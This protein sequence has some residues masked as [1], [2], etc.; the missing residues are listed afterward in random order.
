VKDYLG[1]GV[2][3]EHDGYGVTLTTENGISVTNRIYVDP[4]VLAALQRFVRRAEDAQSP[5]I[6]EQK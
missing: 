6:G 2:Y 5:P 1:D 4:Q 3:V